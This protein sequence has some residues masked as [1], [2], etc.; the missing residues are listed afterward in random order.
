M[1]NGKPTD[2]IIRREELK[3]LQGESVFIDVRWSTMGPV[4]TDNGV[5]DALSPDNFKDG[6]EAN[7]RDKDLVLSLKWV[8]IDPHINDTTFMSFLKL[9]TAKNY[10]DFRNALSHYVAPAQNFIYADNDGNF[11]YQMPGKVPKRAHGHTGKLPVPG[12]VDNYT[13]VTA[14]SSSSSHYVFMDFDSMP[15]TYNP[16][17]GFVASAN[18]RVTPV[19]FEKKGYLLTHD[20][21][22]SLQG[23]R[24]KRI[25]KMIQHLSGMN[26]NIT[27][28]KYDKPGPGN[29]ILTTNDMRTIQLDYQSGWY[30]D[31]ARLINELLDEQDTLRLTETAI[32]WGV[33]LV[34]PFS[35][36]MD[37]GSLESTVFARFMG[38]ISTIGTLETG[39]EHFFSSNYLRKVFLYDGDTACVKTLKKQYNIDT[40]KKLKGKSKLLSACIKFAALQLNNVTKQLNGGNSPGRWGLDIHPARFTNQIL[41]GTPLKCIGDVEVSVWV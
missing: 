17:K 38:A 2:Y 10:T 26:G 33:R 41:H 6:A 20:W 28:N 23:Y 25:T 13:W 12:H 31:F 24:A 1:F 29:N 40:W 15:R 7:K 3:V 14:P 19:G 9:N 27:T 21:D 35:G 32:H 4:I 30:D 11:G 39:Q 36:Y 22:A 8:S 18:N 37:V 5:L 16:S 34:D